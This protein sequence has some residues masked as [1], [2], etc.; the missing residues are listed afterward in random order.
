[1]VIKW[2]KF[3]ICIVVE[4]CFFFY[5]IQFWVFL[6]DDKMVGVQFLFVGLIK[7]KFYV[8]N[9]KLLL[10]KWFCGGIVCYI[11]KGFVWCD[12]WGL[13]CYVVN[14]VF[15]V[16]VV[17]NYGINLWVYCDFVR[18]QIDYMLGDS[19]RSFVVGF[20]F[21]LFKRFYYRLSF[22]LLVF[23]KCGWSNFYDFKFNFCVLKGVLV[24]GFDVNDC[25]KDD[26]KDYVMNEVVIDYNVGFQF[27]VV[28]FVQFV[29]FQIFGID[30]SFYK[31]VMGS[32]YVL[33][34]E[35]VEINE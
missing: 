22:C 27:V 18:K 10:N 23:S 21:N 2:I 25:Y 8:E 19:G 13:N 35:L 33:V 12:K 3:L 20:G 15:L 6:W 9:I 7:K 29:K 30:R 31:M 5:F 11:L 28:G 4:N 16:L 14:M 1:M 32:L 34:V 24:G 26:R 17:V